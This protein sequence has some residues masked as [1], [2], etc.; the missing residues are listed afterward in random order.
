MNRFG[1][2]TCNVCNGTGYQG[3]PQGYCIIEHGDQ[4]GYMDGNTPCTICGSK[5]AYIVTNP[6]CGNCGGKGYTH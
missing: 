4:T 6:L 1:K 5:G 3:K 2:L